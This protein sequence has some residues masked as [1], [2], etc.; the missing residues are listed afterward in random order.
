MDIE[1]LGEQMVEKLTAAGLVDD[2]ADLYSLTVE[3]LV[4][5]DRIGETSATNLVDEI[6]KSTT[7]P[8]PK[9]LTARRAPSRTGG[10][11]GVDRGVPHARRDH[12]EVGRRARRGRRRRRRHRHTVRDWFD[13]E[14][15]RAYIEKFR[16]AG[17]DFGDP[18]AV[19]RG[20]GGARRRR[21]RRSRGAPSS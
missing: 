8:L 6:Q 17:V 5:L 19:E 15:N 11:R 21:R 12:V 1:G 14:V 18:D 10:V 16:A 9:F 20:G 3:Q 7:R 4:E 2:A 13:Q